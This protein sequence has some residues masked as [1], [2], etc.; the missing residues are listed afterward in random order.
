MHR[1]SLVPPFDNEAISEAPKTVQVDGIP[2]HGGSSGMQ[3]MLNDVFTM[4]DVCVEA[5]GS[6]VGVE[7]EVESVDAEIED[8]NKGANKLDELLKYANTPLHGN[9]NIA[10][11][12]LLC[13]YIVLSVWAVG[14]IH[15]SS[16]C[17][18]S[19]KS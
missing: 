10:K 8:F 19:L 1:G 9:T 4:H 6:Q 13:V 12:E 7:A 18:N 15:H 11:W 14:A 3:D 17:S 2:L 5:G 16:C